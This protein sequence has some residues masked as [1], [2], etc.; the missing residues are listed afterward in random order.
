[1]NASSRRLKPVDSP[2]VVHHESISMGVF[3]A[4]AA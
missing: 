3:L 4:A 1:L 2:P